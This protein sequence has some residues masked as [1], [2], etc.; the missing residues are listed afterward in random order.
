MRFAREIL[1]LLLVAAL[2][3]ATGA[4][5]EADHGVVPRAGGSAGT[6]HPVGC[7]APG[8]KNP[9]DSKD[10]HSPRPAPVRHQCCLTGHDVAT[11]QVSYAAEPLVR[12]E[13]AT[14][15]I[16]LDLSAHFLD[17]GNVSS[18]LFADPPGVT[19]LRI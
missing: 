13:R 3:L 17:G 7:H 9:V 6:N 8:G 4:W 11:V 5:A 14:V 1:A 16:D 12:S 10:P 2:L 19:S 18:V 15:Q